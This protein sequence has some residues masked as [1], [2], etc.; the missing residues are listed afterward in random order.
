MSSDR[1]DNCIVLHFNNVFTDFSFFFLN[2]HTN[3]CVYE[4]DLEVLG[5]PD[6]A[7][8]LNNNQINN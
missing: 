7:D 1:F 8:S 3:N 6:L 5:R 2:F 4:R